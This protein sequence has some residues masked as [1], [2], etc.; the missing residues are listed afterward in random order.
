MSAV[1][2]AMLSVAGQVADGVRLH[3]FST[4][5][6]LE[7]RSLSRISTGLM[8]ENRK[9]S[10]IE[11]I[12]GAFMATGEDDEAVAK[13]KEYIRFRISFY[14]STRAYWDVLRLHGLEELGERLRPYPSQNRWNEMAAL[15]S[16]DVLELFAIV[17]RHDELADKISEKYEGLADS[18]SLFIP[19]DTDPG[20]IGE[21]MQDIQKIPM[22]FAGADLSW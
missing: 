3:P 4:K 11:V 5:R 2:P 15:I 22:N 20:P 10:Q 14:C 7:E 8:K 17:G 6:Y 13:M 12:S 19:T 16:D 18:L 9:R 1:G 21:V